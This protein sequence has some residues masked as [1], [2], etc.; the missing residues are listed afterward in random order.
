M[1]QRKWKR[2]RTARGSGARV[3]ADNLTLVAAAM[4]LAGTLSTS[5]FAVLEA[6][7]NVDYVF[8]S[9]FT[10]PPGSAALGSNTGGTSGTP[11][12]RGGAVTEGLAVGSQQLQRQ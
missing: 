12:Q 8:T 7:Q 10:V 3:S 5:W 2:H 1:G 9:R 4:L 11:R 6:L